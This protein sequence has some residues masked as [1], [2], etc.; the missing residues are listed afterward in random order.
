MNVW[1][2]IKDNKVSTEGIDFGREPELIKSTP[3]DPKQFDVGSIL[4]FKVKGYLG[5]YRRGEQKY[6]G[7]TVYVMRITE[8]IIDAYHGAGERFKAEIITD[9]PLRKKKDE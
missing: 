9:F 4:T 1:I 5:W 2:N 7:A 6:Y 3:V 8:Q